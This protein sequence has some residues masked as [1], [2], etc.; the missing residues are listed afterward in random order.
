MGEE[1]D[2][3]ILKERVAT[4]NRLLYHEKLADIYG[5]VSGRIPGSDNLLIKPVIKPLKD[6]MPED[7]IT[8]GMKAYD[9]D[10][11]ADATDKDLGKQ[12][13]APAETILHIA[14]YQKRPDVMGVVHSHQPL[15]TCYGIAGKEILPLHNQF[16][17]FAPATPIYDKPDLI[18]TSELAEEVAEALGDSNALLLKGHGVVVVGPS[19]EAAV[20]NTIYLER[21]AWWQF[22]ATLMGEPAP[23]DEDYCRDF[24]KKIDVVRAYDVFAYYA[25]LMKEKC[26]SLAL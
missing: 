24:Y 20:V 19:V 26:N 23:L 22:H 11:A 4:G 8:V 21:A 9:N 1:M 10:K 15:A 16:S 13:T 7:I 14:V 3:E 5:H 25:S 2:I 17:A 6:I 18:C 12:P